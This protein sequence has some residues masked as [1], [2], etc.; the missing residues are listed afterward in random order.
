MLGDHPARTGL[1]FSAFSHGACLY[2]DRGDESSDVCAVTDFVYTVP[3]LLPPV[4]AFAAWRRSGGSLVSLAA[5]ASSAAY[6][7]AAIEIRD[8]VVPD[9]SKELV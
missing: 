2:F 6:G 8:V 1:I 7:T 9:T 5:V 4:P 3:T